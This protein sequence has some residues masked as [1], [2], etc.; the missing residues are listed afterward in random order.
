[1]EGQS[2]CRSII[3]FFLNRIVGS[4]ACLVFLFA[5][6]VCIDEERVVRGLTLNLD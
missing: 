6:L 3:V 4:G 2:R 5:A 1:M